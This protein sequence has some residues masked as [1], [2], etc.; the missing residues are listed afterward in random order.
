MP[1]LFEKHDAS[2]GYSDMKSTFGIHQLADSI[3]VRLWRNTATKK[4]LVSPAADGPVVGV[5]L[6]Q[7][8]LGSVVLDRVGPAVRM[9]QDM[10]VLKGLKIF[11][12]GGVMNW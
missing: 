6:R 3:E 11:G 12:E 9:S 8:A 2:L 7:E 5:D 1:T 10:C 4:I